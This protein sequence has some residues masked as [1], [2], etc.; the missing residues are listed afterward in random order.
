M[1]CAALWFALRPYEKSVKG[2]AFARWY[3]IPRESRTDLDSAAVAQ[4]LG[5]SERMFFYY[6]KETRQAVEERL[7]LDELI[8]DKSQ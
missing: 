1:V 7:W 6:L 5:V 4:S 2:K 3:L 8:Q